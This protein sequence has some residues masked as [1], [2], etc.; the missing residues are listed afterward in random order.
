MIKINNHRFLNDNNN[1]IIIDTSNNKK[2]KKKKKMNHDFNIII[3]KKEEEINI[4]D[5]FQPLKQ[6]YQT[7]IEYFQQQEKHQEEDVDNDA[8]HLKMK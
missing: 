1:V 7:H 2:A 4:I 5:T 3:L 6:D 8:Q